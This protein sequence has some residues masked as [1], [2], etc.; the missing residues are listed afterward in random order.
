M[1]R[2]PARTK[3]ALRRL[4]ERTRL[5]ALVDRGPH[6]GS[7]RGDRDD[8]HLRLLLAFTL[9]PGAHCIDV[10]AHQGNL[11]RHMME[12][13]PAGRHLAYEPLPKLAA[14]LATRFPQAEIRNAALGDTA[15]ETTFVHVTNR[16]AYSGFRRR[17]LP[18]DATTEEIR[19]VVE[20][21][22][23]S[24]PDG[25]HP[26]FVKVDVEGAELQVFRGARE[27]LKRHKPMVWFEHGVGAADRYG[28][29]PADV[30]ELLVEDVGPRIFDA[31]GRG[32][33]SRLAFE[34]TFA[35]GDIFNFVARR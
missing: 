9:S 18:A 11:L 35:R 32:P 27:T 28:T 3:R 25:F 17:A 24:L 10:G 4:A 1:D 34:E 5:G 15:G 23:D 6:R 33:Y 31:D 21:L 12:L 19:V 2:L 29:R 7:S 16:P 8:E 14:E 22:D 26:E 30:Y 20:R 13:A